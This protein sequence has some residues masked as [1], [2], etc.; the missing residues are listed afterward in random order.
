MSS[1]PTASP[2]L[3]R[4]RAHAHDLLQPGGTN[5]SAL[6]DDLLLAADAL[7]AL[8]CN[9]VTA[10]LREG[11]PLAATGWQ[12]MDSAPKEGPFL[13]CWAIQRGDEPRLP[14]VEMVGGLFEYEECRSY[15]EP[16]AYGWYPLPKPLRSPMLTAP[17]ADAGGQE[18]P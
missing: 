8:L 3:G 1:E 12:P 7:E 17:P 10:L 5:A 6:R 15:G 4:L 9:A 16:E 2:L 18:R 13:V 14:R 11:R